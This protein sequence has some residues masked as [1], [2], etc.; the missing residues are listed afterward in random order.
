MRDKLRQNRRGKITHKI[1]DKIRDN[2][3]DKRLEKRQTRQSYRRIEG[4]YCDTTY[5]LDLNTAL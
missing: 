1:I 3:Q 2:R 5:G 4:Q